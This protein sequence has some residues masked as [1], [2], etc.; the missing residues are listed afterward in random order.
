MEPRPGTSDA[1]DGELPAVNRPTDGRD[2]RAGISGGGPDQGRPESPSLADVL[3]HVSSASGAVLA[4]LREKSSLNWKI[5][6]K[7][8]GAVCLIQTVG[9]IVQGVDRAERDSRLRHMERMDD[10]MT[11]IFTMAKGLEKRLDAQ[12]DRNRG[13]DNFNTD[14]TKLLKELARKLK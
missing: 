7:I 1:V 2:S 11:Q 8:L 13:Q 12:D 14:M 6:A 9:L 10:W 4:E 3:A 5:A